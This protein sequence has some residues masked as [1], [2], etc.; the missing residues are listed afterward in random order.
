MT[1]G[2]V[3]IV[4]DESERIERCLDS[5]KSY[6]DSYTIVDT[7]STDDTV[8]KIYGKIHQSIPVRPWINFGHNRSESYA[9]AKD[10]ADWLLLMDADMILEV[11]DP[12][13]I[14]KLDP[15]IEAYMVDTGNSTWSN[16]LPLLVRGDL[17]WK[18]KGAVHE[19]LAL[20]D[21]R[22]P[23]VIAKTDAI[24]LPA[25]NRSTPEKA[26]RYLKL[27]ETE[28]ADKAVPLNPR[29][30]FYLAMTHYDLGH[31][32]KALELYRR[33]MQLLP[34]HE[35]T[36]YA[37]FRRAELEKHWPTRLEGL[38]SA[39]DSRPWRLEPLHK[40]V[41]ELNQRGLH[42]LAYSLASTPRF[43]YEE[44]AAKWNLTQPDVIFVHQY[45][46]DWGMDF[47]LS[48]CAQRT[49][50]LEEALM[51]CDKLLA[52]ENLPDNVREAVNR[53]RMFSLPKE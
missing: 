13:W 47:E 23:L 38:L 28:L 36:F 1:V 46:Y 51:L 37:A 30:L 45:V 4:K 11:V 32:E 43:S 44:W 16:Y 40:A 39:W 7:G 31:P 42:R 27:L 26:Q 2:L 53:N 34:G 10:T 35:E 14:S 29:T 21:E 49:G 50:H 3:M 12:D 6:V 15:K 20:M 18:S 25:E 17:P 8:D 9:L 24:R 22:T 33:R 48:I 52:V 19:A 41:M 5:V